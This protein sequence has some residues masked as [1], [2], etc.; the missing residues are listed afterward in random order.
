MR[1]RTFAISSQNE[2]F[3]GP[4]APKVP[5]PGAFEQH[6]PGARPNCA[7]RF[8]SNMELKLFDR[9]SEAMNLTSIVS[10]GVNAQIAVLASK[11]GFMLI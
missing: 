3:S 8:S 7:D 4:F 2:A 5:F 11:L 6:S 10:A 1:S 9:I